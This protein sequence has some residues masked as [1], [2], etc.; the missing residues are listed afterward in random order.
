MS[1]KFSEDQ[2]FLIDQLAKTPEEFKKLDQKDLDRVAGLLV[3]HMGDMKF[4][5]KLI[6]Y[7]KDLKEQ[8]KTDYNTQNYQLQSAEML[9]KFTYKTRNH[10]A[11][12]SIHRKIQINKQLKKDGLDIVEEEKLSLKEMGKLIKLSDFST[13]KNYNHFNEM[14]QHIN[15]HS[16][17]QDFKELYKNIAL[18]HSAV[19]NIQQNIIE[20]NKYKTN[21]ISLEN[22][23][24]SRATYHN[25]VSLFDYDGPLAQILLSDGYGH[26]APLY[27][28]EEHSKTKVKQSHIIRKYE[29]TEAEITDIITA[30]TLRI[31]PCELINKSLINNLEKCYG[32]KWQDHI[33]NKYNDISYSLHNGLELQANKINEALSNKKIAIKHA[34]KELEDNKNLLTQWQNYQA[35]LDKSDST[36]L[37]TAQ[38]NIKQSQENITYYS[39]LAEKATEEKQNLSA[40]KIKN[41]LDMVQQP[42]KWFSPKAIVQGHTK[43]GHK[44]DFRKRSKEMFNPT[45]ENK[46]MICSEFGAMT[47]AAS[48]DQLNRIV[49]LDL[50]AEGLIDKE[51]EIFKNPIPK[52]ER[53]DKIH[54]GRLVH[55][56]KKAGAVEVRN[57]TVDQYVKRNDL[58]S[59]KTAN[60]ELD[61]PNK[62][63]FLLKNSKDKDDFIDKANK[64]LAIYLEAYK[65]D[66]EVINQI[67]ENAQK[68]FAEFHDRKNETGIL[69]SIKKLCKGIAVSLHLREK[70]KSTKKLS[71]NVL[72]QVEKIKRQRAHEKTVNTKYYSSFTPNKNKT[73]RSL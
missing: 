27:T 52:N 71:G 28:E 9:A 32:D 31:D 49:A 21:D 65:F 20:S 58:T 14:L 12:P 44:N 61:L 66:K 10:E 70:E 46:K 8:L 59:M 15:L 47:I 4:N 36:N 11:I 56:L 55:L 34:E 57:E 72:T 6:A 19:L 73:S 40:K 60:I 16:K 29:N 42:L 69:T 13:N 41:D 2:Q 26:A 30:D 62:I 48:I 37:V 54:P 51:Q 53:I 67:Q 18:S 5:K 43:L 45:E 50:Q 64:N 25:K 33:R 17:N 38:S 1:V 22:I 63:L 68:Q 23:N 39:S 3:K 7:A 35:Q 24:K